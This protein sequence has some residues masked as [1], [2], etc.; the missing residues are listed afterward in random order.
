MVFESNK[1][2]RH[3]AKS[4][5]RSSHYMYYISRLGFLLLYLVS[6]I[7]VFKSLKCVPNVCQLLIL[8]DFT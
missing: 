7:N 8:L 4:N 6:H 5:K 1:K 3:F 2:G